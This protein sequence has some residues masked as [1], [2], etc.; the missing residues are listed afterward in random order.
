MPTDP[1]P[2]TRPWRLGI[3]LAGQLVAD[4]GRTS[5]RAAQALAQ[6]TEY[7]QNLT[8]A[9]GRDKGKASTRAVTDVLRWFERE[10]LAREEGGVIIADDLADVTAWIADELEGHPWTPPGSSAPTPPPPGGH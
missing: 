3:R 10:E 2:G 9:D 5:V 8:R 4:G 7:T 1:Q 6:R